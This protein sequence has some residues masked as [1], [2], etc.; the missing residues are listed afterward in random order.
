MQQKLPACLLQWYVNLRD[1]QVEYG[2][3]SPE[4]FIVFVP[5]LLRL[6]SS[7]DTSS[8]FLPHKLLDCWSLPLSHT[9]IGTINGIATFVKVNTA[10]NWTDAQNFCRTNH[11]DLAR[12]CTSEAMWFKHAAFFFLGFL[13]IWIKC[14]SI[15]YNLDVSTVMKCSISHR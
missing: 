3:F 12:Y 7:I 2:I 5:S 1:F 8:C 11:V 13:S 4:F 14:R 6:H 9:I 15:L 10:M